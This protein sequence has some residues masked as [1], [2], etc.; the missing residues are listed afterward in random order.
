MTV[1]DSDHQTATIEIQIGRSVS[2]KASARITPSGLL[3]VGV[4]T[5]LIILSA[6]VLVHVSRQG[7]T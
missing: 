2:F 4:L 1:P 5:S 6:S 3:S 7:T